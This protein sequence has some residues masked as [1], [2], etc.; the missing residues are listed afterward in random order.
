LPW[1]KF[2]AKPP[3]LPLNFIFLGPRITPVVAIVAVVTLIFLA[4]SSAAYFF[5]PDQTAAMVSRP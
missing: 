4:L 1:I 3:R 2:P 5:G